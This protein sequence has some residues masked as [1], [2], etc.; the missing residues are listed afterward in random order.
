MDYASGVLE[1]SIDEVLSLQDESTLLNVIWYGDQVLRKRAEEERM[2][3]DRVVERSQS[4]VA[5]HPEL[6]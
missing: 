1:N 2:Y 4:I 5:K 3:L 6:D